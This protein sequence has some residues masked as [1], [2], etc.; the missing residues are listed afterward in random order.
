MVIRVHALRKKF[1]ISIIA[2]RGFSGQY[3][4][5]TLLAFE[6]AIEIGA[7]YIETDIQQTADGKLVAFHD[8]TTKRLGNIDL[9]IRKSSYNQL[10]QVKLPQD[11]KIPLLQ[12][13]LD[14][15]KGKIGLNLELKQPNLVDAVYDLVD[16]NGMVDNVIF[17]SFFHPNLFRLQK[18]N[19]QAGRGTL[20]PRH[21]YIQQHFISRFS[22]KHWIRRAKALH[23]TSI[24][25]YRQLVDAKLCR[26]AHEL[27]IY[28]LPWTVDSPADW[29]KMIMAGVDG[30]MTNHPDK[31]M[32]YLKAK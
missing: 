22:R 16:R 9:N 24:H 27:G 11:Q 7:D 12:E 10:L 28:I 14:I 30:I 25:P 18:I 4:E 19:P 31:L 13:L 29:Q 5:N 32:E 15:S 6:K 1:A 23:V 8:D 2:H 3:T 17:S 26:K 20:E 21:P